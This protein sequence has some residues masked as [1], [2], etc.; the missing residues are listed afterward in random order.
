MIKPT[1]SKARDKFKLGIVLGDIH[2]PYQ[3]RQALSI[4]E[5]I[6]QDL[7]PDLAIQV[8][9]LVD[10]YP[11]SKYS[12]DPTRSSGYDLEAELTEARDFAR[13]I[14]KTC[15]LY[16][17]EGNHEK[18]M[19]KYLMEKAPGL[20]GLSD[21]SIKNLLRIDDKNCFYVQHKH[22]GKLFVHHGD[23][24]S[25]SGRKNAGETAKV[26]VE[27][28]GLSVML[29]HVHRL[30]SY[31]K[32]TRGGEFE[33]YEVGCLCQKTAEY[34]ADPNWQHGLA[35]VYYQDNGS[36]EF[37]VDLIKIKEMG[38]KKVAVVDGKLYT[39]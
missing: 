5:Q 21:L 1:V 19:Q 8:G 39:A 11:V 24:W 32:T 34:V 38:K 37:F 27:A 6:I 17:L 18:R 25:K 23:R 14:V 36:K 30:G 13:R 4:G 2:F 3:D 12:K 26:I 29:G 31:N 7:K 28:S 22:L 9:D 15:P 10:A 33:G 16:I 35:R 20:F